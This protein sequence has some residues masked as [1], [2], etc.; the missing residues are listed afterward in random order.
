MVH[1]FDRQAMAEFI[2]GSSPMALRHY[3]EEKEK[4]GRACRE[5]L[6]CTDI[7]KCG[8]VWQN[9]NDALR[10]EITADFLLR[11]I[12]EGIA[13]CLWA[14]CPRNVCCEYREDE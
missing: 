6:G 12:E 8:Y 14:G 9:G 1:E 4:V 5:W 11:H 10:V 3:M 13:Y 2:R 7:Q